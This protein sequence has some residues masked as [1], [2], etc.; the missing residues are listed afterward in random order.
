MPFV[1]SSFFFPTHCNRKILARHSLEASKCVGSRGEQR[2]L[3]YRRFS[4][5]TI[6]PTQLIYNFLPSK[7]GANLTKSFDVPPSLVR[8]LK[9]V[10]AHEVLEFDFVGIPT[11]PSRYANFHQFLK[12]LFPSRVPKIPVWI[13]CEL[14]A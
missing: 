4:I 1:M 2:S 14:P 6:P 5:P 7:R 3:P 13:A 8:C 10:S 11:F 9:W 12:L